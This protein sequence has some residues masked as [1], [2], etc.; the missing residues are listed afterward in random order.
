MIGKRCILYALA[1]FFC[2][3]VLAGENRVQKKGARILER[4]WL[5]NKATEVHGCP[6]ELNQEISRIAWKDAIIKIRELRFSFERL[7]YYKFIASKADYGIAAME[8][9]IMEK[10]IFELNEQQQEGLLHLIKNRRNKEE[11]FTPEQ[12]SKMKI[13]PSVFRIALGKQDAFVTMP[14]H[15]EC[16]EHLLFIPLLSVVGGVGVGGADLF[17]VPLF[18][19]STGIPMRENEV[20][21]MALIGTGAG[22][23]LGAML[24]SISEIGRIGYKGLPRRRMRETFNLELPKLD[25]S[26]IKNLSVREKQWSRS[27]LLKA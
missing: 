27:M 26:F 11:V 22:A 20:C 23:L 24:F 19:I 21:E 14:W 12:Y 2:I 6:R 7:Y 9:Q 3:A 13:V 4:Y 1:G 5:M 17:M 25:E 16:L 18:S 8:R 10:R 15:E